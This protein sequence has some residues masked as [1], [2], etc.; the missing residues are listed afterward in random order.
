MQVSEPKYIFFRI[1]V[2]LWVCLSV[3]LSICL[4]ACLPAYLFVGLS[5]C[6]SVV[7]LFVCLTFFLF[8]LFVC[9]S[10]CLFLTQSIN[11]DMLYYVRLSRARAT[12]WVLFKRMLRGLKENTLSF[13]HEYY[14]NVGDSHLKG[15]FI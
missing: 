15:R 8:V 9:L 11:W 14:S 12:A 2:R 3:C 1:F 4:S 13:R 7:C 6:L 10:V 5:I